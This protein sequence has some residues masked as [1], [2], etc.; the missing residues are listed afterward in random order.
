[1]GFGLGGH[2]AR[3]V[4]EGGR[5]DPSEGC[6]WRLRQPEGRPRGRVGVVCLLGEGMGLGWCLGDRGLCWRFE[7]YLEMGVQEPGRRGGRWV[8]FHVGARLKCFGSLKIKSIRHD[9]ST[10]I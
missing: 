1:M 7:P 2:G 9:F 5:G 6:R 3:L 4:G 8:A 10:Q